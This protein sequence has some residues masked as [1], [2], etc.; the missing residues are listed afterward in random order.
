LNSDA[1]LIAAKKGKF[2]PH[3]FIE[4]D[5]LIEV[6]VVVISVEAEERAT[7]KAKTCLRDGA[8]N[9]SSDLSMQILNTNSSR[10]L[11]LR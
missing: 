10:L 7:I 5:L 8:T 4:V 2:N 1:I 11:C 9:L 3:N 6:D